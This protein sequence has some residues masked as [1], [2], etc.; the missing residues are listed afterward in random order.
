MKLEFKI[1]KPALIK[2]AFSQKS[3]SFNLSKELESQLWKKYCNDPAYYLLDPSFIDW[4]LGEIFIQAGEVGF[5]KSF[6]KTANFLEKISEEVLKSKEFK[7]LLSETEKYK[8]SV[9]KQW[10]KNEKFVLNY[11]KNTLGLKIPKDKITVYIFHPKSFNG[12]AN[13]ETKTIRW[14]HSEDWPNYSTVYLAHEILHIITKETSEIMHALI[15]LA[16]DNELR[17]RLNKKGEYFTFKKISN[18]EKMPPHSKKVYELE[19]K[20]YPIWKEFLE[21][22]K[23]KNIFKLKEKIEKKLKSNVGKRI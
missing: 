13:P 22:R 1:N 7:K 14:G 23:E 16:T 17:I 3:G 19:K 15:Q 4:G 5:K 2:D 8:D 6:L 21:S 11:F 9:E 18:I 10:Q 12:H 20:I